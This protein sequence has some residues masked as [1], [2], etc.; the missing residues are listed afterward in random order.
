MIY[1]RK[2]MGGKVIGLKSSQELMQYIECERRKKK[3]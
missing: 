2:L 1:E 3:L